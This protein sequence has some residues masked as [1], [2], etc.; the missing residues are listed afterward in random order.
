M[1]LFPTCLIL[2]TKFVFITYGAMLPHQGRVLIS[3]SALEGTGLFR[4][5][6]FDQSGGVV[7][8][9][10]G[11]YGEPETDIAMKV[12]GLP[13]LLQE[14]RHEIQER[15]KKLKQRAKRAR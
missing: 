14:R 7:W 2:L 13:R 4:F 10:Q 9:H 8:N 1:R 3:G 11:T 15:I 5:A 6:L 12:S